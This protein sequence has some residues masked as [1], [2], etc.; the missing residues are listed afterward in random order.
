VRRFR[1]PAHDLSGAAKH[2]AR[3]YLVSRY[4]MIKT[5]HAIRRKGAEGVGMDAVKREFVTARPDFAMRRPEA[6]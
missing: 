2:F 6:D 5:S 3:N 4:G 1:G